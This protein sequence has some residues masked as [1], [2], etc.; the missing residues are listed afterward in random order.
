MN[1]NTKMNYVQLPLSVFAEMFPAFFDGQPQLYELA[2][3]DS[4]YIIRFLPDMTRFEI[5]YS[6]D[7]NWFIS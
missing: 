3:T 4:K 6:E 7:K 2:M 1:V 5:G